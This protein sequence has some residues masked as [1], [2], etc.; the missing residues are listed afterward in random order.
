MSIL[1]S[2]LAAEA[3]ANQFLSEHLSGRDLDALD[4]LPF[5][6]KLVLA[7]Q[8]AVGRRLFHR[9]EEPMQ[10][11]DRLHGLRRHLVHPKP[12][13]ISV[14]K[15]HLYER[16]G[17]DDYNPQ[18]AARALIA[19]ARVAVGLSEIPEAPSPPDGTAAHL[20][21]KATEIF[22]FADSAIELPRKGRRLRR[23]RR[24]P[25]IASKVE[26]PKI[27]STRLTDLPEESEGTDTR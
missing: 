26:L 22:E 12:R 1:F 7:P 4:R 2:T 9:G 24:K 17:S 16:P 13:V 25:R 15:H 21:S 23:I 14:K 8:V 3:Y 20:S 6:E 10:S 11:I 27:P 5:H 19:V 18:E